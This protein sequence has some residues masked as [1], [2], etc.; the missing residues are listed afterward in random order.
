M[1]AVLRQV[2]RSRTRRNDAGEPSLP[3]A[4][5]RLSL[6]DVHLYA[7]SVLKELGT[8]GRFAVE[9]DPMLAAFVTLLAFLARIIFGGG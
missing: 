3:Y 5:R 9:E 7:G 6:V 8:I 4:T 2:R 1:L